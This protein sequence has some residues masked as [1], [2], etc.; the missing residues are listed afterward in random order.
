M[1]FAKNLY[2]SKV[3]DNLI[4]LLVSEVHDHRPFCFKSYSCS[5]LEVG[6]TCSLEFSGQLEKIALFELVND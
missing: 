1:M 4:T 6:N 5:K 2:I 3:V